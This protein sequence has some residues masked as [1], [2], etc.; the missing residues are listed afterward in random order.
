MVRR[1]NSFGRQSPLNVDSTFSSREDPSLGLRS[2]AALRIGRR[3]PRALCALLFAFAG[4]AARA[5]F[6]LAS[7]LGLIW[8]CTT[9]LV[10]PLPPS[11][12]VGAR[13]E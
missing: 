12:C 11:I 1:Q 2:F 6:Q 5:S 7:G 9:L 13:S 3:T 4:A 10:C 8:K